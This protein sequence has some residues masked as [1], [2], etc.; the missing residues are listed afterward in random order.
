MINMM[1]NRI[2]FGAFISYISIAINI[3]AGLLYLPWMVDAIGESDYGLFTLANSLI[4]L[5]LVDFGLSAATARYISKYLA[6]NNQGKVNSFITAVS[7]LYAIIDVVILAVLTVFYFFIDSVFVKLT[8][9]ELEKFKVVYIIAASYAIVS[10]PFVTFNGVL[11][12]YEKFI[13]LKIADIVFRLLS[14]LLTVIA[15]LLGGGLYVLVIA[16]SLAGTITI[17][18]KFVVIKRGT[19]LRFSFERTDESLYKSIFS[20]SLWTT[21]TTLAQRLIFTI[22]PS[23]LGITAD[24]KAIAVFGIITTIEGY[25]YI[26]ATAINGMF[27]P[28]VARIY[29]EEKP[30]EN[31]LKLMIK[32]GRFQYFVN[33]LIVVG[34]AI[35]G[36]QFIELWMGRDYYE[37]YYGIILVIVPSLIYNPM[38]IANTAMIIQKKV[39]IQAIITV[40]MGIANVVLSFVLSFFFGVIGAVIS[41]CIAYTFRAIAYNIVHKKIMK[42]DM[43]DFNLKCYIAMLPPLIVTVLFGFLLNF[44][45]SEVSWLYFLIRVC[46]LSLVYFISMWL[47]SFT[48][49][50][51]SFLLNLLRRRK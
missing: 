12:A 38:Q 30:E 11:T 9:G 10:F 4:N 33:G 26:I 5:F 18:Y 51:K 20:F 16:N 36:K 8:P 19:P 45:W 28:R 31:L 46:L 13:H 48:K 32:V 3:L 15:L 42:L 35:L 41:I 14:V 23:I 37:A 44:V 17:I 24:S 49:H 40:I 34:F 50:E 2:K 39:K 22:T 25:T 29:T 21:I 1:N 47:M 6:E 27:M 7:K 43:R